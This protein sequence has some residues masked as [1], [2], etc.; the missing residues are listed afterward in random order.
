MYFYSDEEGF[1]PTGLHITEAG[2]GFKI[3]SLEIIPFSRYVSDNYKP[4]PGDIGVILS[5]KNSSWR[6]SDREIFSW[7]LFP[8]F[9]LI[10]FKDYSLQASF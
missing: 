10:D 7:N 5:Y 1:L 6:R 9:L 8:D 4:V 3:K 2:S